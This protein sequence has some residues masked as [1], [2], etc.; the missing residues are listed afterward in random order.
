MSKE[1]TQMQIL[2]HHGQKPEMCQ[3]YLS[4]DGVVVMTEL[5]CVDYLFALFKCFA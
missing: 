3:K 1:I 2:A 4:F 5:I